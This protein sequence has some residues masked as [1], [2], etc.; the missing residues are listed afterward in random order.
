MPCPP[1]YEEQQALR[2]ESLGRLAAETAER[3][4]QVQSLLR[5]LVAAGVTGEDVHVHLE[6]AAEAR[7]SPMPDFWGKA[8]QVAPMMAWTQ[9][10]AE[11][12]QRLKVALCEASCALVRLW[13]RTPSD[14]RTVERTA[15][16][17]ALEAAHAEHRRRDKQVILNTLRSRL[18][19]PDLDADYGA[20]LK[21]LQDRVQG[22]DDARLL[23]VRD[24]LPEV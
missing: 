14:A 16:Y 2:G 19:W 22:L 11:E 6:A 12:Y 9:A 20:H 1:S 24:A 23:R 10:A 7:L 15:R 17:E 8:S 3:I 13:D 4:G 18:S 21:E 5:E